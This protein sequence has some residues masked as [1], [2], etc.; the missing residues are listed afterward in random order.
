M[1][2]VP[3]AAAQAPAASTAAT[4]RPVA[5][6]GGAKKRGAGR[7]GRGAGRERGGGGGPGR[8]P[9]GGHERQLARRPDELQRGEHAELRSRVVVVEH[10]A[11]PARLDA[12]D[13]ERV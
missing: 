12:L 5:R 11:M 3:S 4:A 6:R 7:G 10:G 2:A 8:R 1:N 9:A 13:D